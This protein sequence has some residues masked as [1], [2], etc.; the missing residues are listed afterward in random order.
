MA[1]IRSTSAYSVVVIIFSLVGISGALSV[2]IVAKYMKNYSYFALVP[3]IGG[4]AVSMVISSLAV[5][6]QYQL[7]DWVASLF[8]VIGIESSFFFYSIASAVLISTFSQILPK[9]Y[10]VC[11]RFSFL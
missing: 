3:T 6:G 8:F 4:V 11:D 2:R 1:I 10:V 9:E 7:K 5:V